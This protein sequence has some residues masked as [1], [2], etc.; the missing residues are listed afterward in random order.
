MDK[1][2]LVRLDIYEFTYSRCLLHQFLNIAL[3]LTIMVA[4]ICITVDTAISHLLLHLLLLSLWHN[5][6]WHLLI[7]TLCWHSILWWWDSFAKVSP[8]ECGSLST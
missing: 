2:E 1:F 4:T 8:L 3:S 6:L 5:T 7:V